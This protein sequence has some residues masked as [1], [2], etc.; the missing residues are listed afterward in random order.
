STPEKLTPPEKRG[1][2]LVFQDFALFPNMTAAENVSFSLKTVRKQNKLAL[3][4]RWLDT[5]GIA[6]RADAY[7]H[8][9]S[10]G[11]QQRIA[12]ARTIAANP[13]AIMMDEPFSGLDPENRDAVRS[14]AFNAIREANIP[15]LLVTHDPEEALAYADQIAIL[16]KGQL[17]QT[18]PPD[19]IYTKPKSKAVASAFGKLNALQTKDMPTSWKTVLPNTPSDIFHRPEAFEVAESSLST[20]VTVVAINRIGAAH[21]ISAMLANG[22]QLDFTSVLTR[23]LKSGDVIPVSPRPHLFYA[24]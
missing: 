10:G 5:L 17:L 3:A 6:H 2:G 7:P 16:D 18:G 4:T 12:I 15:T 8:H 13:T 19:D 14:I 24:F 9:L 23:P 21:K 20:P 1:I 11:E 22:T